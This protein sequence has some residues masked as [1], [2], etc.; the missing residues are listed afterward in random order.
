MI[1]SESYL[2]DIKDMTFLR[3]HTWK[4]WFCWSI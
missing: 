2:K 4:K 1:F 3:Y